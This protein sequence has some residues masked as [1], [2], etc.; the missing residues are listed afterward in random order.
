MALCK[1]CLS[2][3]KVEIKNNHQVISLEC[4][5]GEKLITQITDIDL[6][7]P[8]F[9]NLYS[10]NIKVIKNGEVVD[11]VNDRVGFRFIEFKEDGFY[12]NNQKYKIRGLDRHQSYPYVGYAMPKS[13][14]EDD[15]NILKNKLFLNAVRTSHYP[16]SIDF[17]N[18]L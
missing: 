14:Q 9:P 12:L 16:Q 6:W 5:N 2:L 10:L 1:I 7:S 3:I 11:E 15:A 17:L 18:I 8:E 13:M 4:K